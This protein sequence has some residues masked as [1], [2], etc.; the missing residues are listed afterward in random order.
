[1]FRQTSYPHR[2]LNSTIATAAIV[3]ACIVTS[4][5]ADDLEYNR[6]IRPILSDKCF[7]CHGPDEEELQ[8]D[9]R[10]DIEESA[11]DYAIDVDDL[12]AS[13]LLARI[14]S[15]EESLKMPPPDSGKSLTPA[16]I[17]TLT[18]WVKQGAEYQPFWA[19]VP[20]RR[21]T[22]PQVENDTWSNSDIDRFIFA[23]L[24]ENNLQPS[25]DADPVT[26][27]RRLYFDLIGLPPTPEAVA[28]FVADHSPTAYERAVDELLASKHFGERLAIYWLDLV[29]YA[30]TVGYHG[31]QDQS[32]S[33]YRD[34]VINALN[35]NMP[36]D[37]FTRMQLAG[38]LIDDSDLQNLIATGYN[39]MLQTS[40]E[41]GVQPKEYLAIY[42]ADRVR[43]LSV[44]WMGATMGC[45]QCHNHKFDPYTI[46]DFYSMAAFF[47]DIDEADHFKSGSNALPTLRR[48]E[49]PV[50]T[51]EEQ[52]QLTE[53]QQALDQLPE[54]AGQERKTLEREKRQIETNARRTMITKSIE[55]RE[56]RVLPRGNW[57]DDSGPIVQPAIPA[58]L[59]IAHSEH[60][61]ATR[62]DL[63]NWLTDP[64]QGVGG[65][66]AR[67]QVNRFWYLLFGTG[68]SRSLDDF[69]GQGEPPT[70]PD[71]L[72]HLA[73]EFIDS[74]WNIKETLK[75][76]LLSHAYRQSSIASPVLQKRDPNNQL[77]AR[78]SSYRLPAEMVR[79]NV[80]AI[81]GLL[82]SDYG[83]RSA[84]PY[85]P[86]GYYRHLNFP[87]REY[88]ADQGPS[89]YRRGVYTH[90]QRQF[91]HPMLKA[92]DAPSREECTAQRPRSNTPLAALVLLNDPTFVESGRV[93]AERILMSVDGDDAQKLQLAFQTA[94][95]RN[96]EPVEE[97]VLL[98]LLNAN[99]DVYAQDESAV[100]ELLKIGQSPP[101]A[102]L[103][104]I[105]IASW[106]GV[107]R[108]I[109]NLNET[110]T[111]N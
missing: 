58:F 52:R 49:I 28:D 15:D 81:S 56:M 55:P 31:D 1:M 38:D 45:C 92:F 91:L 60:D 87:T 39:R 23:R 80:L 85:Q 109:L 68:L 8:A 100:K 59:G 77:F 50:Y 96:P 46:N 108:A 71:L 103:D 17:Q 74:G 30:D 75:L 95:S 69:G 6:D 13:E 97:E 42:A 76:I 111:R 37:E 93:F 12:P 2:L 102:E 65:L 66:T 24:N 90:W 16:E 54:D 9:L 5:P 22:P 86:A 51:E 107:A 99:R 40:H 78:Q 72:D 98:N 101:R 36:F 35:E 25:P 7:F 10:L 106:T 19:Y 34:W 33:P 26:L 48:P 21:V 88:D 82:N 32:I 110:M 53:I 64:E 70:Y 62:L 47:A 79:D 14:T 44:V 104:P 43:N 94:L 83:G 84:R 20:P 27:I 63:A 29:R 67:V 4:C 11:K 105:E 3:L 73:L 41:G 89:Q 57:L 18:T 61:R